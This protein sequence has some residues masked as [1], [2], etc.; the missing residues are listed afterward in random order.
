MTFRQFLFILYARKSVLL[1]VLAIAVAAAIAAS[2]LLP[3]KW[4]ATGAVLVDAKGPDPVT[5]LIMPAQML[6]AYMAT[7]LDIIQSQNVAL[8]VVRNM[9]LAENQS[10]REA[11][12]QDTDGRGSID[13]WLAAFL[14]RNL[15]VKPARESSLVNISFTASDPSFAAAVANAFTRAYVDA[16]L[17]L[18]VEP[19]RQAAQWFSERTRTLRQDVEGSA[20]KLAEYQREKGIVSLDERLET[21]NARLEHLN[22]QLS[23]AAAQTADAQTRQ[24]LAREFTARGGAPDALPDVLANSLI[25]NLKAVLSQQEGRLK[26]MSSRLGTRHPQYQ[27]AA[28]EV[29]SA[30]QRLRDEMSSVVTG[31]E[32][33]AQIAA[34]REAELRGQVASQKDRVLKLKRE[35][36]ELAALMR[37]ADNAQKA[38]DVTTQRFNQT[39]LESQATQTNIAVLN[40]ATE[41]LKPSFPRWPLNIAI[42]VFIG[43]LIGVGIA[44]LVEMFDQR[45]RSEADV[46]AALQ[47]PVIAALPVANAPLHARVRLMLRGGSSALQ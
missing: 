23:Q 6:P 40:P 28:A 9:R 18:K 26:E 32:N 35:R 21:E 39:T 37:E 27:A 43:T 12:L 25:A 10:L 24:R 34:R 20:S 4:T 8:K 47:I 31:I 22:A 17:E 42:A 3:A 33:N 1:A 11:W 36:D 46:T 5:G 19:A 16:N 7:Q 44:L 30:R 14:L 45:V 29:E 38:F 41:P 2:A 13:V 15:D